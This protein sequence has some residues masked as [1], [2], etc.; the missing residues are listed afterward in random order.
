MFELIFALL[1]IIGS[2]ALAFVILGIISDFILP[3]IEG[4]R[5]QATRRK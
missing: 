4:D 3:A 5:P 1:S 2:C